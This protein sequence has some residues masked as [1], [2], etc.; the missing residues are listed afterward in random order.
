MRLVL[1]PAILVLTDETK[2]RLGGGESTREE[3]GAMARGF[4]GVR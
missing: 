4:L 1:P 2:C 3:G